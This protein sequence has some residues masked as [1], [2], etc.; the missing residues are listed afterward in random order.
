MLSHN[1]SD[2][3]IT[4]SCQS[5]EL[6]IILT[7]MWFWV[8]AII[9]HS[10]QRFYKKNIRLTLL[11]KAKFSHNGN[12]ARPLSRVWSPKSSEILMRRITS[13]WTEILFLRKNQLNK[14]TAKKIPWLRLTW[15]I[16]WFV[17]H[18]REPAEVT[19]NESQLETTKR[20][21]LFCR[22]LFELFTM[23]LYKSTLAKLIHISL[24]T[25]ASLRIRRLNIER[26]W[27]DHP[28]SRN[29]M[30]CKS[31]ANDLSSE[32]KWNLFSVI[33]IKMQNNSF[34]RLERK[35]L[36]FFLL[37]ALLKHKTEFQEMVWLY[38][39][40]KSDFVNAIVIRWN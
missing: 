14:K 5:I 31:S 10:Y 2:F 12:F 13:Y 25:F 39:Y 17:V 3:G 22:H 38:V 27:I 26:S 9:A 15:V 23:Q 11:L 21:R 32:L 1:S 37:A 18:W 20:S 29:R 36:G 6:L 4:I 30:R 19:V 33:R 7:F 28:H 8:C 40:F 16:F 35:C 34:K 24:A